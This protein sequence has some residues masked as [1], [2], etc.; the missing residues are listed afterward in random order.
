MLLEEGTQTTLSQQQ[1]EELLPWTKNS[2]IALN[3]LL[4]EIKDLSVEEKIEH[5]KIG[6]KSIVIESR[7]MTEL[8]MRYTLNRALVIE[9]V[10]NKETDATAIGISDVKLRVLL[11]SI[12]LALRYYDLDTRTI[13]TNSKMAFAEYGSDYFLFLLNLNKSIFDASA[14]YQI[15]KITLEWL[16][17]DLYRDLD[18]TSFAIQITKIAQFLKTLPSEPLSDSR[19][20]VYIRKMRDLQESLNISQ[21]IK[22]R[23]EKLSARQL[24]NSERVLVLNRQTGYLRSAVVYANVSDSA[25]GASKDETNTHYCVKYAQPNEGE[26]YMAFENYVKRADILLASGCGEKFCVG[27]NVTEKKKKKM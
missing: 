11:N 13:N 26:R 20:L 22:K 3:E 1:I 10:I 2:K 24:K 27:T 5:L 14:Q 16:A 15:H 9:D 4:F 25:P 19:T 12:N 7:P 8:F 18:N 23:S 21:V 17:W 6:I